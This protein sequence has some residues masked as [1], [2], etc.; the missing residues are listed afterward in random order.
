[1]CELAPGVSGE[2]LVRAETVDAEQHVAGA[3][4]SFWVAGKDD[5]WFGGTQGDRMDLLPEKKEYAAGETARFQVRMPFRAATAL[6]TV[7]REGVLSSFVTR[8]KGRM[9]VIEVPI[10]DSYA[11][12]VFVS[13]L[14]VRGRVGAL[15]GG[16]PQREA[17]TALVDLNKP[18]Y[19]LGVAKIDVGWKPHRLNVTVTP[20]KKVFKVAR[21]GGRER[22]RRARRRR[23]LAC[24][25]RDRGGS[26]R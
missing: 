7:E 19:R 25:H 26:R 8:L 12:N 4:T 2:V 9:P 1:M 20:E 10:A 23:R 13:V 22:S 6:V 24:G 17:V 18:A 16:K 3:T 5:W 15:S 11:P 14:A 21:E